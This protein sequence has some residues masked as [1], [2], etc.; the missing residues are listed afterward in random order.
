[1]VSQGL[2]LKP[3]TPAEAERSRSISGTARAKV[4]LAVSGAKETQFNDAVF[5]AELA[6]SKQK[7]ASN[8]PSFSQTSTGKASPGAGMLSSQVQFVLAENKMVQQS[9]VG[10]AA[11]VAGM[12]QASAGRAIGAYMATQNSVNKTIRRNAP[13]DTMPKEI[14]VNA[15]VMSVQSPK[16]E[17]TSEIE[18]KS[19]NSFFGSESDA[20]PDS[21]LFGEGLKPAGNSFFGDN[22]TPQAA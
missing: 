21:D 4:P 13:V 19:A 16:E 15:T 7:K 20:K 14:E 22:L 1:M 8:R 17:E 11:V 3:L 12:P 5:T 18:A 10:D 6:R 2:V 9:G